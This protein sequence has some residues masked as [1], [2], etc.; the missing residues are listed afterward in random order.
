MPRSHHD[1]DWSRLLDRSGPVVAANPRRRVR[2][3]LG[4]FALLLAVLLVRLIELEVAQ[5]AAFRAEAAAPR[6][7]ERRLAAP[8]GRILAGDGTVLAHDEEVTGLAIH[9]RYL[10]EPASPRW[11]RSLA[12][13]RLSAAQRKDA[14]RIAEMKAKVLSDRAEMHSRLARLCG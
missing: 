5:G 6:E 10:E 13:Q 9:Y 8:R 3:L 14:A 12:R 2:L 11:L 7:V 1:F 4:G